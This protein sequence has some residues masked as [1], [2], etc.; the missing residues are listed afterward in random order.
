M[1]ITYRSVFLS[2]LGIAALAGVVMYFAFPDTTK[3]GVDKVGSWLGPIISKW[4]S[5]PSDEGG[6]K[7]HVGQQ[8]AHFVN[9]DGTVKVKKANS[10]S[11]VNADYGLPLEKGDYIRTDSEGIAKIVFTDGTNYTV[12]QDSLIVV[13]ENSTNSAQQTQVAVQVTTGTVDLTTA[14]LSLGSKTQVTVAGATATFGPLSA[15]QVKNDARA[16]N[17]EIMLTKGQGEVK[18]GTEVVSL[19]SYE[20]VSFKNDSRQMTKVKEIGPPTLITP[21]NMMPIFVT[22]KQGAVTFNWTPVDAAESYHVRLSKNPYFSS[23]VV[24]KKVPTPDLALAGLPEGAYYW[25][26]TAVDG[27]GKESIESEKNRFTVIPKGAADVQ[28]ALELDDF[29]QQGHIIIVHGR[30]EPSARVMVNGQEVQS[31]QEDGSFTFFTPQLPSGMNV[32]T[33]TAQNSKGGV[34]TQTRKIN[35]D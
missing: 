19:G 2:I 27:K 3:A 26:V 30:T 25:V 18:R 11:W 32:I 35:I 31:M 6:K 1:T 33:V 13:E 23:T 4:S 8:D 12:K 29:V 16:D 14:N 9:I 22:G 10:N 34:A 24:D 7:A 15:A 20:R 17:H 5:T 28:L 21:A